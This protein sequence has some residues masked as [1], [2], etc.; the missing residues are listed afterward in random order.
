MYL[1]VPDLASHSA[2][3]IPIRNAAIFRESGH[4][5]M[6]Y[7]YGSQLCVNVITGEEGI[8]EEVRIRALEPIK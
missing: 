7:I 5:F 4:L 1:S 3:V 8:V 6:C 2:N